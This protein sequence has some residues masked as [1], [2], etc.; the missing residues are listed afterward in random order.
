VPQRT[1]LA[2]TAVLEVF[3]DRNRALATEFLAHQADEPAQWRDTMELG[4][5]DYWLTA[6]ELTEI[7]AA[8]RRVLQPYEQC[9]P[10]SRPDGSRRVRI[11]RLIV[12]RAERS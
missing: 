9:R 4:N 6:G 8:L 10:G 7:S 1:V 11:A 12:P 5:G 3:M 2:Q